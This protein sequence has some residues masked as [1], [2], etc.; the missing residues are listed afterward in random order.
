MSLLKKD[1]SLANPDG[2]YEYCVQ[3]GFLAYAGYRNLKDATFA[4][5]FP[6]C[7]EQLQANEQVRGAFCTLIE[8]KEFKGEWACII[9]N[10][11]LILG[12][13]NM[14]SDKSKSIPFSSISTMNVKKGISWS[15]LVLTLNSGELFQLRTRHKSAKPI[16]QLIEQAQAVPMQVAATTSSADELLK[17]KELLDAGLISLEEFNAKKQQ[18]L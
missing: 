6:V 10:S 7:Y 4:N 13:Q 17:Y 5:H 11:R 1:T 8:K 3:N 9:T 2:A 14:L 16:R 12:H 15:Y 18:L